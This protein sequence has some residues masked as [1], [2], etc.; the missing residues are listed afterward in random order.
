MGS[1]TKWAIAFYID[2]LQLDKFDKYCKWLHNNELP[3][4]DTFCS[5]CGEQIYKNYTMNTW[6]CY[7]CYK[8][9]KKEEIIDLN[10]HSKN[11][12][13]CEKK[14]MWF[15]EYCGDCRN[16]N[17]KIGKYF[18]EKIKL[19]YTKIDSV[20]E[21]LCNYKWA[22]YE[23]NYKERQLKEINKVITSLKSL[24]KSIKNVDSYYDKIKPIN[25]KKG[26]VRWE[27]KH[28]NNI[29][30]NIKILKKEKEM[31]LQNEQSKI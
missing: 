15:A 16:K 29:K 1:R 25:E 14:I 24:K 13:H 30:Y 4:R 10:P 12:K 8:T 20:H 9:F 21:F 3:E 17:Y 5:D 2:D 31:I 27:R 28:N 26:S 7:N 22:Y 19:I 23:Y 6:I 18:I 11:C